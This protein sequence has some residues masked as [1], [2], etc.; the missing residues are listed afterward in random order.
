MSSSWD[1][2]AIRAR[3]I[4]RS[5]AVRTRAHTV[6]GIVDRMGGGDAFAAGVL[7]G[8]ATGMDD[9]AT[10]DFAVAAACLKHTVRGDFNL[11][12]LGD[13]EFYLSNS[14]SDVRR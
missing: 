6:T 10:L 14:G 2:A 9:Q 11:A 7:H 1:G 4:S 12:S 8:L 13:V 3:A 5:G